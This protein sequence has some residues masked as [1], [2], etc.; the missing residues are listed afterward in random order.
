[1]ELERWL[2]SGQQQCE[3]LNQVPSTQLGLG[4]GAALES[5]LRGCLTPLSF[6]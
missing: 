6:V 5:Q 4:A 2:S 1:M 3:N